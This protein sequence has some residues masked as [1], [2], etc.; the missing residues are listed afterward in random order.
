MKIKH[1][2]KIFTIMMMLAL[3]IFTTGCESQQDKQEKYTKACIELEEY[4]KKVNKD[5]YKL[6]DKLI[7]TKDKEK[8]IE[9]IKQQIEICKNYEKDI[10]NTLEK[11]QKMATG[12]PELEKDIREKRIE[13]H[14]TLKNINK[15]KEDLQ[16]GLKKAYNVD[17]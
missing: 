11:M 8:R 15:T 16:K 13:Y 6:V 10:N 2:F 14:K 5:Y 12:N 9:L 17:A 7:V 4:H 3:T 1:I